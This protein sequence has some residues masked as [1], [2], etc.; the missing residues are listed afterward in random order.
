MKLWRMR[1][2]TVEK[3]TIF[4]TLPVSK[5]MHLFLGTNVP[6]EIIKK[7]NQ[8]QKKIIWNGNNPKIKHYTLCN[9]HENGDLKM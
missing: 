8:K 9:K 7:Q 6:A 5:I 2:L 1:D 3:N 4:K